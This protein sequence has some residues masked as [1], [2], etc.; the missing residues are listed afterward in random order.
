MQIQKVLLQVRYLEVR[1]Y[2]RLLSANKLFG[3]KKMQTVLIASKVFGGRL[4]QNNSI[5]CKVFGS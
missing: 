2:K 4:I 3:S 1:Y 5:K